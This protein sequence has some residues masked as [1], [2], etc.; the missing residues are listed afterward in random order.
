MADKNKQ[1]YEHLI[2]GE[3][4]D[5]V[6]MLCDRINHFFV[7]LIQDF[8]PLSQEEV[9]YY[10]AGDSGTVED[11]IVSTGKAHLQPFVL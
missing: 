11:F 8:I 1:W 3:T 7:N 10:S 6:N 9:S 5:S 4:V 2:D